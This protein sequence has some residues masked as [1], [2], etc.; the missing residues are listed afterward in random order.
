MLQFMLRFL[1]KLP[2]CLFVLLASCTLPRGGP[3]SSSL[4]SSFQKRIIRIDEKQAIAMNQKALA[5]RKEMVNQTL[6]DLTQP[7]SLGLTRISKG[8]V[9]TITLMSYSSDQHIDI[10]QDSLLAG[11][12]K[13]ELGNYV[14]NEHCHV[15][16]PYVGDVAVCNLT[17]DQARN[18]IQLA[19]EN[20]NIVREPYVIVYWANDKQ[21]SITV[22]GDIGAP[23]ILPWR[24]GGIKL[25]TALTLAQN[26]NENLVR[27]NSEKS[28]TNKT[29][30]NIIRR[31]KTYILPY[32]IALKKNIAL[33]PGDKIIIQNRPQVRATLMGGGIIKSGT[34]NF[35]TQPSLIEVLATAGGFNPNNADISK[36]FV[37]RKNDGKLDIYQ[38]EFK[39]GKGLAAAAFFPVSDRD[40]IFAPEATIVPWLRVFNIAFQLALPAAVFK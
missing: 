18:R 12:N 32:D 22:T 2:L 13:R 15:H 11:F 5:S 38:L 37:F 7:V 8:D 27:N 34:Y 1:G 40:I 3:S 31:G 17:K 24:A 39:K 21:N 26:G 4:V 16:L 23:K 28:D 35:S 25:S 36:I 29:S 20:T 10:D 14:V 6:R 30:V 9:L 33:I 19:Y